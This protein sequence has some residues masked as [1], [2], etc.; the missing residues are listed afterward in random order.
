M[1]E[2]KW[3]PT[4]NQGF[5]Y[6]YLKANRRPPV[7]YTEFGSTGNRRKL[8][9]TGG[10]QISIQNPSSIGLDR[11]TGPVRSRTGR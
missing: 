11:Y 10:I 7:P 9:E 8:E 2:Q 6:Q 1:H 5:L 3:R 4:A